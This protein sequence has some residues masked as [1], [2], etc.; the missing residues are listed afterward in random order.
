[1][2]MG[3]CGYLLSQ[4]LKFVNTFS[5]KTL[6][7]YQNVRFSASDIGA[8]GA[9]GVAR[10]GVGTYVAAGAAGRTVFVSANDYPSA[11]PINSHRINVLTFLHSAL[12]IKVQGS[13][14]LNCCLWRAD[15]DNLLPL[16][17]YRL[18]TWFICLLRLPTRLTLPVIDFCE[19]RRTSWT[20]C[21]I[22]FSL[23]M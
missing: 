9:Q 14:L 21:S 1:M 4:F 18:E 10:S 17:H 6:V 11:D 20:A 12:W 8:H 13:F 2:Q 5:Q 23:P 3:S 22:L 7:K 15:G 16:Y 19:F